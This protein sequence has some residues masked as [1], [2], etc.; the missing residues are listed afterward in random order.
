M[1]KV[2]ALFILII[3]TLLYSQLNV[4]GKTVTDAR[5]EKN[6]GW[7]SNTLLFS[8]STSAPFGIKY[9]YCRSLGGYVSFKTDFGLLE[10]WY[11]ISLGAVKS[12]GQV[13]NLYL[14]AGINVGSYGGFSS[15][16]YWEQRFAPSGSCEG[17]ALLKFDKIALDIGIGLQR[18]PWEFGTGDGYDDHEIWY[19]FYVSY[20]IGFSF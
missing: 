16:D 14:G 20:G 5:R 12:V 7:L 15:L 8:G 11:H 13:V 1:K 4:D 9:Q 19:E 2:L 18:E 6:N 3:P 10:N 17:G